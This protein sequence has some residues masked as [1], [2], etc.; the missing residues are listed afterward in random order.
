M[1]IVSKI[2]CLTFIYFILIGC[3]EDPSVKYFISE[4]SNAYCRVDNNQLCFTFSGAVSIR[5]CYVTVKQDSAKC[6]TGC[7]DGKENIFIDFVD[8]QIITD[9]PRRNLK[10][11]RIQHIKWQELSIEIGD[12]L[13]SLKQV[14]IITNN[15]D[16]IDDLDYL[17]HMVKNPFFDFGQ[18]ASDAPFIRYN[19]KINDEMSAAKIARSFVVGLEIDEINSFLKGL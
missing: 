4:S 13:N 16:R 10:F 14:L 15:S 17:A 7:I 3:E 6:L 5:T 9:F 2:L 18:E 11:Q 8:D 1:T 19:L 12:S